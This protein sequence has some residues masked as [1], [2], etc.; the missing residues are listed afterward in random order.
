MVNIAERLWHIR[1]KEMWEGL[2]S[3]WEE[4]LNEL[5]MKKGTASKLCTLY[6]RIVIELK[7]PTE[8]LHTAP[9]TNLY[10]ALP[11]MATK[12]KAELAIVKAQVLTGKELSQECYEF[13]HGREC[14]HA[15]TSLLRHCLDCRV[16]MKVYESELKT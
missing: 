12:E 14:P 3:S 15:H 2:W 6:E 10:A 11:M 1:S 16:Y 4:F 9:W 5:G 8:T 13:K 7:F